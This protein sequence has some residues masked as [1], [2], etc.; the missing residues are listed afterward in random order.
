MS[1]MNPISTPD[2]PFDRDDANRFMPIMICCLSAF[3]ALL[4]AFAV[5]LTQ[6]LAQ[7][8]HEVIGNVQV[9][10]PRARAQD[11]AFMNAVSSSLKAVPGVQSV[12]VLSNDDINALLKPWLGENYGVAELPLP[13]LIDVTTEVTGDRPSV[14]LEALRKQLTRLDGAIRVD[15]RGPWVAQII[16][17]TWMLRVVVTCFALLILACIAGMLVLLAKTSLRL[18]FKVVSLLHTF[19]ATDAYILQQFQQ[20]SAMLTARGAFAGSLIAWTVC[21][22]SSAL[23]RRSG[24]PML[25]EFTLT[26]AHYALF[27]LLPLVMAAVAAL[28]SRRAVQAMLRV[29]H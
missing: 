10:L 25:P 28:A 29:M 11:T 19:G 15:D 3:A 16:R 12:R 23:I 4:L 9:E 24:N 13:V 5:S 7:H 2:I 18:H 27:L 1:W 21:L 26:S 22:V 6:S 17:S 14:D 20:N 8:S